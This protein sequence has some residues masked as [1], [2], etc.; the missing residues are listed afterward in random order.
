MA[1]NVEMA[2]AILMREYSTACPKLS[3]RDTSVV[4]TFYKR[5]SSRYSQIA[6]GVSEVMHSAQRSLYTVNEFEWHLV[7]L[8]SNKAGNKLCV[9]QKTLSDI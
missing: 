8:V 9:I 2:G 1:S 7:K 6:K 3:C 4:V 5:Q